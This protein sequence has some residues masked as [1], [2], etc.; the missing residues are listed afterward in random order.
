MFE[1]ILTDQ[2]NKATNLVAQLKYNSFNLL[3]R[4]SSSND[5]WN[6]RNFQNLSK[7]NTSIYVKLTNKECEKGS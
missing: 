1:H 2:M 5:S 3:H 4:D 7:K 6:C